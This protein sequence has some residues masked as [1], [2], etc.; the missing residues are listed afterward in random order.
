MG[1]GTRIRNSDHVRAG[2]R[3]RQACHDQRVR[4]RSRP[5]ACRRCVLRAMMR[6]RYRWPHVGAASRL[7][8]TS[9]DHARRRDPRR[10]CFVRGAR[11]PPLL[12]APDLPG[13]EL[14]AVMINAGGSG[15]LH[16][17]S[18]SAEGTPGRFTLINTG[19]LHASGKGGTADGF[20]AEVVTIRPAGGAAVTTALA[21]PRQR[22]RRQRRP[23]RRRE[24]TSRRLSAEAGTRSN[25]GRQCDRHP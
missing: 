12:R 7:A 8:C 22:R 6:C 14:L 3:G 5:S 1:G 11:C 19:V 4:G 23:P 13:Q 10:P 24:P 18:G 9:G 17:P 15:T 21:P 20:P 25:P 2:N 16:A